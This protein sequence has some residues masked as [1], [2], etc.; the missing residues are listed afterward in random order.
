[1]QSSCLAASNRTSTLDSHEEQFAGPG[2][3]HDLPNRTCILCKHTKPCI[4]FS[5]GQLRKQESTCEKCLGDVLLI[6]CKLCK[7]SQPISAFSTGQRRNH[8]PKCKKC[9]TDILPKRTCHSLFCDLVAAF[10]DEQRISARKH[11]SNP[12]SKPDSR[13]A[14]LIERE[15]QDLLY[16]KLVPSSSTLLVVPDFLLD[17]WK[18]SSSCPTILFSHSPSAINANWK[19][20]NGAACGL[21]VHE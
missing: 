15:A 1:M 12:R 19:A 11:F 2:N 14:E 7:N 9:T 13:V 5:E 21:S 6:R 16:K 17:H 4:D 8:E 18:V 10:K 20:A 3:S